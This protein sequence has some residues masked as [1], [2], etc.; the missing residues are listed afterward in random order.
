MNIS[1]SSEV[2]DPDFSPNGKPKQKTGKKRKRKRNYEK[3]RLWKCMKCNESFATSVQL[4]VHRPKHR[5]VPENTIKYNYKFDA[6]QNVFSCNTCDI[7]FERE[8]DAE[9]HVKI[10]EYF[11]CCICGQQFEKPYNFATHMYEHNKADPFH[12]PL[13]TF[14]TKHRSGL[15]AHINLFHLRKYRYNCEKCH[16]G[17]NDQV[18]FKEHSNSHLGIKPFVCVVC[19]SEF[20]YSRYLLSHQVR[21]HRAEIEGQKQVPNQCPVC[22]KSF[23]REAS[24]HKHLTCHEDDYK[25]KHL[26]DICGKGFA[27]MDK[28]KIH[29]RVHTGDKPFACSYCEKAFTKKDYLIMHERIH[30]GEKPYA[31]EYCGKCFNQ[32]APLRIHVRSHTGERP[33]SCH[34]CKGGFISKGA[35]NIHLRSCNGAI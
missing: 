21:N 19:G 9:D 6:M 11:T 4:R 1:E 5:E 28:M 7:E 14:T 13:C 34:L 20:V 31:C 12:C 23:V 2:K 18:H 24:L 26:C 10:H 16:K 35:L 25:K 17:F 29:Y 33:Y 32:G 27:R 15:L 3:G 30:S 8:K 22:L